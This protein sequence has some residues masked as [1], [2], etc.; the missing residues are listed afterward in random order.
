[1]WQHFQDA[2]KG[3]GNEPWGPELGQVV[4]SSPLKPSF[5]PTTP[6]T[7]S[8]ASSTSSGTNPP[9]GPDFGAQ[10]PRSG[11][12]PM[13]GEDASASGG[14]GSTQEDFAS[15]ELGQLIE[16]WVSDLDGA[17]DGSGRIG[18]LLLNGIAREMSQLWQ[19]WQ[20]TGQA[21]HAEGGTI[22][23]EAKQDAAAAGS[24][25]GDLSGAD[26]GQRRLLQQPVPATGAINF[27][28]GY[29]NGFRLIFGNFFD[30]LGTGACWSSEWGVLCVYARQCDMQSCK[31]VWGVYSVV[32][33]WVTGAWHN[34]GLS[35]VAN[36]T[37][38]HVLW[39][40]LVDT[41][42]K[43]ASRRCQPAPVTHLLG[44]CGGTIM[45]P[46]PTALNP[47]V[48]DVLQL[49]LLLPPTGR[50]YVGTLAA[51]AASALL[52]VNWI[53]DLTYL[54]ESPINNAINSNYFPLP[55]T[56]AQLRALFNNVITQ[57]CRL[58]RGLA[59]MH[60]Y[61]H[62]ADSCAVQHG[63]KEYAHMHVQGTTHVLTCLG[64]LY[65]QKQYATLDLVWNPCF[66]T[67]SLSL[68]TCSLSMSI[69]TSAGDYHPS[70][71]PSWHHHQPHLQRHHHALH[72]H[73][74]GG[75]TYRHPHIC[76]GDLHTAH[77]GDI[78]HSRWVTGWSAVSD[79]CFDGM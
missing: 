3:I 1:M 22:R 57:Y 29:V 17:A 14:T 79:S 52:N 56:D 42:V 64:G 12:M 32:G 16:S 75:P 25:G 44:M 46:P 70:Q 74:P 45:P 10:V 69:C 47:I 51:Q 20:R 71:L 4:R 66:P 6:I 37:Q 36:C 31:T 8:T 30:L 73:H 76:M 26:G 53:R 38:E 50:R 59:H 67:Y 15:G 65:Y 58:V 21:P 35:L 78:G 9:D 23:V 7:E 24:D 43:Q 2:L 34:S 5:T 40:L 41:C 18:P 33:G 61:I 62:A 27:Q 48:H 11:T 68:S 19:E 72:L 13:Q 63:A 77:A 39:I 49:L 55:Q 54:A 60:A 28:P